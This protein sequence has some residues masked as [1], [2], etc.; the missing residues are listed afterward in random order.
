VSDNVR[1]SVLSFIALS[2]T[3][4][5]THIQNSRERAD[6]N[7]NNA[8]KAENLLACAHES[9]SLLNKFPSLGIGV[10]KGLKRD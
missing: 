2:S 8:Q 6:F 9:H 7:Q 1:N 3:H 5:Y 10:R 4:T